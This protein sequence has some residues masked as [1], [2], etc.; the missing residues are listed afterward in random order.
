MSATTHE[1][2][3]P[4]GGEYMA[5]VDAVHLAFQKIQPI[6][7]SLEVMIDAEAAPSLR[8]GAPEAT[9]ERLGLLA[10][11]EECLRLEIE[12]LEGVLEQIA[13]M[14]RAVTCTDAPKIGGA[15]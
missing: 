1:L 15:S 9:F 12:L 14:R 4:T 5:A 13:E 10:H 11:F 7:E 8:D 3:W 2:V 6:E